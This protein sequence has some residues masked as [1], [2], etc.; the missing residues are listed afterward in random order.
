MSEDIRAIEI[1]PRRVL[2]MDM[3]YFRQNYKLVNENGQPAQLGEAPYLAVRYSDSKVFKMAAFVP[4]GWKARD[5]V[6]IE[7]L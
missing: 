6:Y 5:Y 1:P 3:N 7:E 4:Y 2:E